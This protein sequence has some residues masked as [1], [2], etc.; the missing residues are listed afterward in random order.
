MMTDL[1][2][3][4]PCGGGGGQGWGRIDP[5]PI[6][7]IPGAKIANVIVMYQQHIY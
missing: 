6:L 5:F 4:G 7:Y 3:N 2:F 1:L